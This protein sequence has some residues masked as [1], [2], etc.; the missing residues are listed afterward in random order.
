MGLAPQGLVAQS[1]LQQTVSIASSDSA[2][3]AQ[4]EWGFYDPEVA[5]FE[6][7]M[8][9][10]TERSAQDEADEPASSASVGDR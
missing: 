1:Q 2:R 5:G 7:V 6:A 3:P 4:D 9:R 10:L 8:R